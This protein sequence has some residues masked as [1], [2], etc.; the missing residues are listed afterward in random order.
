MKTQSCI[1]L[2]LSL[3]ALSIPAP[4]QADPAQDCPLTQ[5]IYR[6]A[7]GKGFELAF[8][9]PRPKTPYPASA[10]IQHA[11]G[12]RMYEF[13]VSQSSG[14]GSVWLNTLK[15]YPG[16]PRS[17]WITFFDQDLKA[18]TP[19]WL[20]DAKTAPKYAAIA[21]LGGHD[22]YRRRG[23]KNPPLIGDVMWRFDRC[24]PTK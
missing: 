14:Y 24:Q 10:I 7:D 12:G 23:T 13:D 15:N 20:L 8:S 5:S 6:D 3:I 9:S 19:I 18:A 2:A 17:F 11:Q 1:T 21:E 16:P 4:A 22:H